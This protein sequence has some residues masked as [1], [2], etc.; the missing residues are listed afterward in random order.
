VV[1]AVNPFLSH[2]V[3]CAERWK[4]PAGWNRDEVA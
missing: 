3:L 4:L 1:I 2:S